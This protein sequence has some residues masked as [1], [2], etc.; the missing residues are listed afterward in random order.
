M[1]LLLLHIESTPFAEN[2]FNREMSLLRMIDEY[3]V[4][5][6]TKE[7]VLTFP[8]ND[9]YSIDDTERWTNKILVSATVML[10]TSSYIV[11][12]FILSFCF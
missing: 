10:G 6:C 12:K 3:I 2:C 7:G 9:Y 8:S 11:S 4:P 1:E 5:E